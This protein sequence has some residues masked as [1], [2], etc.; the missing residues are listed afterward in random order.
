MPDSLFIKKRLWHRWVFLG[1]F[2]ILVF[3]QEHS[4][5]TGLQGNGEGISLTPHYHFHPF[6]RHL[7]IIRAIAAGGSPL[8]IASSRTRTGSLWFPSA[9]RQPLRY[10][11]PKFLRTLFYRTPLLAA[12]EIT[13]FF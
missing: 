13:L 1:F 12:S 11:A 2:S 3:F 7:G 9:S 5:I 6:Y 10:A 8:H 4:R